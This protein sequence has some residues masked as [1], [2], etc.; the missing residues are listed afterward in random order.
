[1]AD[2]EC[3]ICKQKAEWRNEKLNNIRSEAKQYAI[4]NGKMVAIFK[5]GINWCFAEYT[6][7]LG[8]QY[9]DAELVSQYP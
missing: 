2:S 8:Q 3:W 6:T 5:I 1:M 7:E 4:D 9:P